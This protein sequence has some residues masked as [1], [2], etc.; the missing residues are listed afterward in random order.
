[1]WISEDSRNRYL[2]A[3]WNRPGCWED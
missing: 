1:M 2:L 3:K